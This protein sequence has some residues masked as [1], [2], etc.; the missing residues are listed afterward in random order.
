[1]YL[2]AHL[3]TLLGHLKAKNLLIKGLAAVCFGISSAAQA[4]QTPLVTLQSL[5]LPGAVWDAA[6]TVN[7]SGLPLHMRSFA[8]SQTPVQVAR[9]LARQGSVF[10]RVL[11]GRHK[12]VLSGLQPGWHWLAEINAQ[13][14]G[15]QGYVSALYVEANDLNPSAALTEPLPHWIPAGSQRR[16]SHSAMLPS[17]QLTQQAYRIPVPVA[18]VFQQASNSLQDDGWIADSSSM[19][20]SN[21]RRWTRQGGALT[22]F[23]YPDPLGSAVL[24]QHMQ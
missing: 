7:V 23:A 14:E 11:T 21:H 15:A 4:A 1:M 24:I 19:T 18:Q 12:I 16:F 5:E 3:S 2:K 17:G 8:S 20:L 13:P 22:V 6:S 10:Q 9:A